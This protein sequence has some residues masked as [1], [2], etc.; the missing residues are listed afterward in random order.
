MIPA[1]LRDRSSVRRRQGVAPHDPPPAHAAPG[2][3]EPAQGLRV[4]GCGRRRL[5]GEAVDDYLLACLLAD[6]GNEVRTDDA[7]DP[8]N[9]RTTG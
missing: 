5:L 6:L 4:R 1:P 8:M 9:A 2:V 7:V 3:V